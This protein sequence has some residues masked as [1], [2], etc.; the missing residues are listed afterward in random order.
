MNT[1]NFFRSVK[2]LKHTLKLMAALAALL[3]LY[4]IQG[5]ESLE[6][7]NES[8]KA[9][10]QEA[11]IES[12]ETNGKNDE[13]QGISGEKQDDD[14]KSDEKQDDDKKDDD[15]KDDEKQD[16]LTLVL[17]MSYCS[18]YVWR[19]INIVDDPVLQPY[20]SLAYKDFTGKIW[21]NFDLTDENNHKG[22]VTEID[23]SLEYNKDFSFLCG[24]QKF[25][26]GIIY[27][28]YPN[29]HDHPTTEI[30]VGVQRSM[31]LK[32]TLTYY[33]DIEEVHGWYLNAAVSHTFEKVIKS[34]DF[35]ISAEVSASIAYGSRKNNHFYY[36]VNNYAFADADLSVALPFEIYKNLIFRPSLNGSTLVNSEIR[37]TVDHPENFWVCLDLYYTW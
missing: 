21:F 25:T 36:G 30:Y 27:Y 9:D 7:S 3:P 22:K 14:K 29:T 8:Y 32:P 18:K 16:E 23:Y 6:N 1:L 34:K 31:L 15:K 33:Q 37:K 11:L 10:H 28:E 20:I 4:S 35:N 24:E 12:Q 13:E 2:D 17:D 19:G 26:L 5:E